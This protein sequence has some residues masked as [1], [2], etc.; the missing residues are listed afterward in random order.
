MNRTILATLLLLALSI[1]ILSG[2]GTTRKSGHEEATDVPSWVLKPP[3]AED[4][5]YGIGIAQKANPSLGQ[6]AADSRARDCIV[7][8][9]EV[10]IGNSIRDAMEEVLTTVGPDGNDYTESVSK[11][12]ASQTLRGC[13]IEERKVVGK[14]WYSLARYNRVEAAKQILETA[15]NEARK[16]EALYRKAQ[17]ED[18]FKR[19]DEALEKNLKAT[20]TVNEEK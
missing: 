16:R 14:T 2:C 1:S 7:R 3:H 8:E 5:Y 18:S 4:T 17:A 10:Q 12:I 13:I 15:K 11:Q 20:S 9:I 6:Q 19:L